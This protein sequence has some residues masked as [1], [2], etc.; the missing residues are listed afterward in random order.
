MSGK[1]AFALVAKVVKPIAQG[2]A[3]LVNITLRTQDIAKE[4]TYHL[5]RLLK[6]N[7]LLC[8][9]YDVEFQQE[10]KGYYIINHTSLVGTSVE[11]GLRNFVDDDFKR[12]KISIADDTY[13]RISAA[14]ENDNKKTT[15]FITGEL[16]RQMEPDHRE[17][18]GV[19]TTVT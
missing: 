13:N 1:T 3:G 7:R 19:T 4:R 10:Q 11:T 5:Y 2:R 15:D 16:Y 8:Y 12:F 17:P 9:D 18:S 6:Y 14:S